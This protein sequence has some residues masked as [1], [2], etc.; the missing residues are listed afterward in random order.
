MEKNARY[1][2]PAVEV[3]ASS[4]RK[5]YEPQLVNDNIYDEVDNGWI[6]EN[7]PSMDCPEWLRMDFGKVVKVGALE[8]VVA[9]GCGPKTYEVQISEDGDHYCIVYAKT[10]SSSRT[11]FAQWKAIDAR[12][13]KV[14][15]TESF[16]EDC[17]IHEMTVFNN[18]LPHRA[19]ILAGFPDMD[20]FGKKGM[21]AL[22]RE[23]M[24]LV[25][26]CVSVADP[27]S[28]GI[29]ILP[30]L[31]DDEKYPNGIS[32]EEVLEYLRN[33]ENYHWEYAD[34]IFKKFID[35]GFDI[36]LGFQGLTA[37][38]FPDF[39]SDIV[40]ES[41]R[42]IIHRDFFNDIQNDAVIELARQTMLHFDNNPHIRCYSILGPGWF[43]GIEFYS[44][45]DPELLAVYS[46]GA[47]SKFREWLQKKYKNI[48][49]LNADW[50]T[51]YSGFGE[52]IV[53]KPDRKNKNAVD[54]RPDWADLMLWKIDY[55]DAFVEKYMSSMRSVSDKPIHV[56][57][58]GGYQSAPMETGESI[59][60]IV[61]DLSK[62]E[63]I[64]FGNSNLDA[65]YGTAQFVATAKF[66][67]VEDGITHDDTG[68]LEEKKQLNNAFNF[69][70]RG[71]GT[72]A[73]AS[74]GADF[75]EY[76]NGCWDPDG[77]FGKFTMGSWNP[78]GEYEGTNL[79]QLTKNNIYKF[80]LLNPEGNASDV[81]VFNPWYANLFR[82]GYN[83]NNHNYIYDSDHCIQWYGPAFANWTH[84]LNTP[85]IM[86][87]FPI[88]DGALERKKV[89]IEPNMDVA[90]TS[91]AAEEEIKKWILNGGAFIGF[92]KD[93][94]NY[95]FNL[96]TG[97]IEGGDGVEYWMM[98]MSGG[99]K[100]TEMAGS[101][102]KVSDNA[103]V[104][105]KSLAGGQTAVYKN[106]DSSQLKAFCELEED[107]VP[108]LE[109]EVGNIVMC[110]KSAGKGSILYCT[111]PI[112]A[113]DM[114]YDDFMTV[115]LFDYVNYRE[116]TRSVMYE[117]AKYHVVD[118]G[119]DKKTGKRVIEVARNKGT[120]DRDVLIIGHDSS[121]DDVQAII[122]LNWKSDRMISYK[123]ESGKPFVY[124]EEIE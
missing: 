17:I 116:I 38:A 63:N 86:D 114:F 10:V 60:K 70:S 46:E 15:I 106:E 47:K 23:G 80:H 119:T 29:N 20:H 1:N 83:R 45:A 7:R 33:P 96:D 85:E 22:R 105:L 61:R 72:L 55:M 112:A 91:N 68:Q 5:G 4:Y 3:T 16:T 89:L 93:C 102:V 82:K 8:I 77:D 123:F 97:R 49:Q 18:I 43:G 42:I 120:T 100:V 95:R 27:Y 113:S 35:E 59:G 115:L 50:N 117:G 110:E 2:I 51:N 39:Y 14:I 90:L 36:W 32:N 25:N 54:S 65:S 11:L 26:L 9:K 21:E 53:P 78:D 122:D 75:S 69:L 56:E 73:H 24:E 12:Y 87:D 30:E 64:I 99:R 37:R 104:W 6:P 48:K 98:G 58:D 107:V 92:G 62:Y 124:L 28:P 67:E 44:G 31:I 13:L 19:G 84:Y 111:V 40:D 79:Y 118:A 101:V 103:P 108:I 71:A 52:I 88:E 109:D 76:N 121:L 66:Y 74:L 94:F 81:V 41:G 57:I 34:R